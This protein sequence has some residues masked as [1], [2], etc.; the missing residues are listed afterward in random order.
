MPINITEATSS[1]GGRNPPN[2]GTDRPPRPGAGGVQSQASLN[3]QLRRTIVLANA[4]GLYDAADF[5]R[6][7]LDR[8]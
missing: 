8:E 5:I 7:A 6:D 4:A 3:D 1:K 2:T